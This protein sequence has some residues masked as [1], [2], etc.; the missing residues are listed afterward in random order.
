MPFGDGTGP[1]GMGPMTGRGM[2]YCA[3]YVQPG[4]A[5]GGAFGGGFG[6]GRGRGRGF[7]N[8]FYATGRPMWN[9]NVAPVQPNMS[10]AQYTPDQEID[11]LKAQ[12]DNLKASLEQIEKRINE[13]SSQDQG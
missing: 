5:S 7:R 6:R 9:R 13:L 10:T 8:Q 2:G 3:G 4:Y 1:S 12:A 11:M